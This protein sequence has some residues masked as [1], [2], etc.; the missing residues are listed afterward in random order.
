MCLFFWIGG[1]FMFF[2][3]V[4]FMLDVVNEV[5]YFCD[6]VIVSNVIDLF[7]CLGEKNGV[8]DDI[9]VNE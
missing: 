7:N 4:L 9:G 1:V 2:W 6:D 5:N 3:I 8:N